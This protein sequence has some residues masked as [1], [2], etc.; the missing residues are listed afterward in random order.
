MPMHF[1]SSPGFI[2]GNTENTYL[3]E[4]TK[5]VSRILVSEAKGYAVFA[6][7]PLKLK[8]LNHLM[9]VCVCVN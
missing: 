6:W 3:R 2:A 9:C 4:I 7:L 5:Q 8:F 1:I